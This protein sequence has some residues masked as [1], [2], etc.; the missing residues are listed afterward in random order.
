MFDM[1]E[2]HIRNMILENLDFPEPVNIGIF[3]HVVRKLIIA[4]DDHVKFEKIMNLW[5]LAQEDKYSFLDTIFSHDSLECFKIL[6][7]KHNDFKKHEIKSVPSRPCEKIVTWLLQN[8]TN[9]LWNFEMYNCVLNFYRNTIYFS[10]F[11]IHAFENRIAPFDF[12]TAMDLKMKP[13]AV[14]WILSRLPNQITDYQLLATK[15]L[16]IEQLKIFCK[17][18]PAIW[19]KQSR[20]VKQQIDNDRLLKDD[21]NDIVTSF[22]TRC[23]LP[24]YDVYDFLQMQYPDN[25]HLK[26][27][28][29]LNVITQLRK[30]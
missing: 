28:Y 25:V 4:N 2:T 15:I 13:K 7:L 16:S 12:Y 17:Y 27:P 20:I 18:I 29:I 26:N 1:T 5:W 23:Q 30:L 24:V 11:F 10:D 21:Y 6:R 14:E 3:K 9:N 22:L 8:S 19:K